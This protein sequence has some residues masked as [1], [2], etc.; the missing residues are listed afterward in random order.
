MQSVHSISLI[1]QSESMRAILS[2]ID[3]IPASDSS[4][5]LIGETGVGKEVVAEYIHHTSIRSSNPLIK[6]GLAALPPD[7]LETELFGHAKGAYTSAMS[8]KKGLFELAHTGSI[9]LD[10]IDDFP[11]ALQSKL[12]RVLESRELMRVGGTDPIPVDVR[13]IT[14]SKVDLKEL[15][16][17]GSFRADLYYRINV[18][19]LVIPPLRDRSGDVPLLVNHFLRRFSGD[20]IPGVEDDAMKAM[21]RYSWPGNI[22]ELRNTIQRIAL[23]VKGTIALSDL[24]AEIREENPVEMMIKACNRCFSEDKMSFDDVVACLETNLIRRALQE[25]MGNRT[26]AARLLGMN[27]STLRDKLKKYNLPDQS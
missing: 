2:R 4:V 13:L 21:V 5:L 26:H 11:L 16:N 22:R 19:P 15:V 1:T 23:F 7:L 3:S 14:A 17:R 20:G 10:D 12:L 18:V 8:E 9:F 25:S 24:P 27:L 6:V